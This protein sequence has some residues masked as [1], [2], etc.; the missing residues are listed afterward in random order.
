MYASHRI[1]ER[2]LRSRLR[3]RACLPERHWYI[4]ISFFFSFGRG[5]GEFGPDLFPVGRKTIWVGWREEAWALS[6]AV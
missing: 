2:I 1:F 4:S 6:S 5:E 3:P